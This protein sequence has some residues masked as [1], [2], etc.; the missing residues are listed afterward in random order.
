MPISAISA[1]Q[2]YKHDAAFGILGSVPPN[3]S[4][5]RDPARA[6]QER[7]FAETA[8]LLILQHLIQRAAVLVSA[9]AI[10][11]KSGEI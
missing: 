9:A 2:S 5:A 4:A 3:A 11:V 8:K 1:S 10:R 6:S 7:L